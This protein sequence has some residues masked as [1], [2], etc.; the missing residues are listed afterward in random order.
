MIAPYRSLVGT[1][2]LCLPFPNT[3]SGNLPIEMIDGDD[4]ERRRYERPK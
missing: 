2:F 1:L 3:I 4:N